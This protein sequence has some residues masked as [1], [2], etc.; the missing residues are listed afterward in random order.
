MTKASLNFGRGIV[1]IEPQESRISVFPVIKTTTGLESGDELCEYFQV[2]ILINL[3]KNTL[4]FAV[5][6]EV[7]MCTKNVVFAVKSRPR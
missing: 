4:M 5:V 7:V 1:R 6:E 2:D 3:R